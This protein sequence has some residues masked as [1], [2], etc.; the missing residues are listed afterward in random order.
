MKCFNKTKNVLIS[1]KIKIA[2]TFFTRLK[3]LLGRK[4]LE[5]S[6]GLYIT[7]CPQVHTFFMKFA[8][9]LVFVDNNNK[10]LKIVKN[11]K[12]WRI[13]PYVFKAKNV[14]EF[15]S[16]FVEDKIVENNVLEIN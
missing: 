3:G 4:N 10:V 11:M 15:N 16:G 6:E 2:Q 1:D 13:S 8:I 5:H 12:P 7:K 14:I 9:D